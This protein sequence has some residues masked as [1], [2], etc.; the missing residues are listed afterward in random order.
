MA[1]RNTIIV[2]GLIKY[3]VKVKEYSNNVDYDSFV[4]NT[5]LHEACIFNLLQMGE[6]VTRLDEEFI[7]SFP[8]IP[9]IKIRG[10]RNRIAHDYE[11]ISIDT[12]WDIIQ[13]DLEP[14]HMQLLLIEDRLIK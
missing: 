14:L 1:N 2:E 5:Q 4:S 3:I 13:D 11:S 8:K 9:W 6:L 10:L 12:I 7:L